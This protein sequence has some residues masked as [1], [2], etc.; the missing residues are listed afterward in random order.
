MARPLRIALFNL[1]PKKLVTE[2]HFDRLFANAA[3]PVDLALV[4]P[5]SHVSRNTLEAMLRA[6]YVA[7]DEIDLWRFDA[8]IV[9]GAPV[10][11]LPFEEVG[12]WREAQEV[13][14]WA[15]QNISRSLFIC[16][17]AQAVLYHRFGIEKHML[18]RKAFGVYPQA[19]AV[20]QDHPI[21]KGMG[22]AFPVP[23]ARHTEVRKADITNH[24]ELDV[25]ASSD[26][27]GVCLVEDSARGALMMFNHPEYDGASLHTE[28]MRDKDRDDTDIPANFFPDDDPSRPPVCSWLNASERFFNNWLEDVAKASP[29]L[30][31]KQD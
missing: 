22:E 6:R 24:P 21:M 11:T 12:Y 28:Y 14:D 19:V 27:S 30:N 26:V 31:L 9:T 10:E 2:G 29:R 3:R 5:A 13:F 7:W 15:E 16:W 25:L 18:E 1:M 23:V 8:L 17:A 20:S 4:R